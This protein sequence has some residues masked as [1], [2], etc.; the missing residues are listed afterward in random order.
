[1]IYQVCNG[2]HVGEIGVEGFKT[3]RI[4]KQFTLRIKSMQVKILLAWD[5]PGAQ[6][7]AVIGRDA[8]DVHPARLPVRAKYQFFL[9]DLGPARYKVNWRTVEIVRGWVIPANDRC[10]R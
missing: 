9:L 5:Q 10:N 2:F 1:M 6:E 3:A 4:G 8:G 7:I